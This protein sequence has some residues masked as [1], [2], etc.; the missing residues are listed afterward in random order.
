MVVLGSTGSFGREKQRSLGA[1][2]QMNLTKSKA[3]CRYSTLGIVAWEKTAH[4]LLSQKKELWNDYMR[5]IP[6]YLESVKWL[7]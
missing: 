3:F 2:P 6:L 4:C 1:G 7:A 5:F